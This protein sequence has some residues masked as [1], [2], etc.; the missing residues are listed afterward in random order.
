MARPAADTTGK[1]QH[2][3]IPARR[4]WLFGLV[5]AVL[6]VGLLEG[7]AWA[8]FA[9][10]PESLERTR[11]RLAGQVKA[12]WKRFV[13]QPYLVYIPGPGFSNSTGP[14]HNE[15]GYR[16]PPVPLR[17]Q[18]GISRVLCMGGSTT[19]TSRVADAAQTY[20]A[21]LQRILVENL[22][23]N[24]QG[25]EVINAGL[26]SGTTAEVLT[27]WAF[28]YHLYRPDVVVI[29]TGG[30]DAAA[31][32]RPGYQP[33]YSHWRGPFQVPRPLAPAGRKLMRS[34][35]VALFAVLLIYGADP[36]VSLLDLPADQPPP[37]KWFEPERDPQGRVRLHS[38]EIAFLHNLDSVIRLIRG[39]GA[40][41][42][43]VPFRPAPKNGYTPDVLAAMRQNEDILNQMGRVL[44]V[45][46]APLPVET[47]SPANWVDFCHVNGAGAREKAA[48]IAPYVRQVLWP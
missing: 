28:K 41:V 43:L 2:A 38:T 23:P 8:W 9:W 7:G 14:Q 6:V 32:A 33:D 25:V 40:R 37:A 4:K 31:F 46:V 35:L 48:H 20:P 24:V 13:P 11:Q 21:W 10:G 19:Y 12:D 18:P 36:R 44:K 34:R 17:R 30:N 5:L 39:Q 1:G 47:I 3:A 15:Q 45:P 42:V 27:H 16:G 29:H 22:P 26:P